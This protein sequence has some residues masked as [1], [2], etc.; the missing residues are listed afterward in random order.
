MVRNSRKETTVS[1]AH[2]KERVVTLNLVRCAEE[3]MDGLD[4]RASDFGMVTALLTS[5][6]PGANAPDG[7]VAVLSA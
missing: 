2:P 3:I 6:P 1:N 5:A 7:A 4:R